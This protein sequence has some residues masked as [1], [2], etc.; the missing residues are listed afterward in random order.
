MAIGFGTL[1]VIMAVAGVA[2]DLAVL[3]LP[4][5]IGAAVVLALGAGLGAAALNVRFRDV[6][7]VLGYAMQLWFFTSPV[8]FASSQID[9]ALRVLLGLNP[10]TGVIDGFRWAVMATPPPP[11]ED[12]GGIVTG[13][14]LV[15]AGVLYFERTQRRFADLI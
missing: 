7:Y 3:T 4:L 13:T 11:V 9:G 2:P 12:L 1:A 5:W 8:I 14:A 10:M 6:G 15:L